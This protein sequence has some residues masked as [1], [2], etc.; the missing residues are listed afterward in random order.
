MQ[1]NGYAQTKWVAEQV[2]RKGI[3]QGLPITIYRI[4]FF[5]IY[6]TQLLHQ[7]SELI[8]NL[9]NIYEFFTVC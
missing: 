4:G 8:I 1:E 5:L 9:L 7:Q 6:T 2:L 3:Q